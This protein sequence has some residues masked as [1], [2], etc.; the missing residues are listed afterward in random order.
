MGRLLVF[1]T[2][3]YVL[4]IILG[5]YFF[6]V[7]VTVSLLLIALSWALFNLVRRAEKP[8]VVIPLLLLFVAGGSLACNLS[9]QKAGGNIRQFAGEPCTLIGMVEDEPVWRDGEVVFP[10]RPERVATGG[11]EYP[12][13]GLVRVTLRVDGGGAAESGWEEDTAKDI[14][15]PLSY[16]RKISLQGS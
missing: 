15:F 13:S 12:A 8:A 9:L 2:L 14:T 7:P 11:K 16:G 10:L 1:I 4:G 3:A 5:R 6:S